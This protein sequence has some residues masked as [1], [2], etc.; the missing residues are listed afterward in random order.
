VNGTPFKK[1]TVREP[2]KFPYSARG[3]VF[4][5]KGGANYVCSGTVVTSSTR[6]SVIT[7]GHCVHGGKGGSWVTNWV[8]VPGYKA[9]NAPFGVFPASRMTTL[10]S[11]ISKSDFN[12]D[13]AGVVVGRNSAG[14]KL[15]NVAGSR[16]I[17]FN[18]SRSQAWRA[19]GYPAE[20]KYDGQQLIR[21]ESNY[22]GY[23]IGST[24][25]IGCDM[26]GG[27]SGGGWMIG[28]DRIINSV[29]SYKFTNQPNMMYGPYFGSA[30]AA[31]Y[32]AI[33]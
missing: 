25:G 23:G 18:Q 30:A 26:T 24:M 12:Y 17:A 19:Y 27:S 11:W 4:F 16:G 21:C 29:N 15:Q 31:V 1:F 22:A 3:K 32:S 20:G 28:G 2:H 10:R 33:D 6:S 5:T 7:A 9:G 8:F 13:I 14:Q